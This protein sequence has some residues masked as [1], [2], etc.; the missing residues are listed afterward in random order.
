MP[1]KKWNNLTLAALTMAV[2]AFDQITKLLVRRTLS[3]GESVSVLGDVFRFTHVENTG[4]VF[5]ISVMNPAVYTAISLVASVGIIVY[6]CMRLDENP[7]VRSGLAV[8][9]GGAL[10]NLFDRILFHRVVDFID[11]GVG[12]FRW[13]VFNVADAAVVVGMGLLLLATYRTRDKKEAS[14]DTV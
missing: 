14:A 10:G 2:F 12:S 1:P 11:L 5:G 7:W 6:L 4:I 9:L 3:L 13:Y 8:M